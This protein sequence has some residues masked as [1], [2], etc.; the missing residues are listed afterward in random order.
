M[1]K[2]NRAGTDRRSRFG[3][4]SSE[5]AAP[6]DDNQ[7][8]VGERQTELAVRQRLDDIGA[9]QRAAHRQAAPRRRPRAAARPIK[10][11]ARVMGAIMANA[12][13]D[14]SREQ[15]GA[16]FIFA[17]ASYS[18]APRGACFIGAARPFGSGGFPCSRN[19][20]ISP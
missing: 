16:G 18:V 14:A 7:P 12:A 3:H 15:S 11:I 17:G 20:K 10:I 5:R 8:L 1:P 2:R 13:S 4:P 9:R 6:F 19:L